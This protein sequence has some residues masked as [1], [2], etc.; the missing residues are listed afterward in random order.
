MEEEQELLRREEEIKEREARLEREE[1][2]RMAA[3]AAERAAQAE[4]E[5]EELLFQSALPPAEQTAGTNQQTSTSRAA[6]EPTSQTQK[7]LP[8][9]YTGPAE[10]KTEKSMDATPVG[11]KNAAPTFPP[12]Q[13]LPPSQT[14]Q[15]PPSQ[16]TWARPAPSFSAAGGG[17]AQPPAP[18]FSAAGGGLAEPPAPSFSAA[19]GGLAEPPAPSFSAAGGD[20]SFSVAGASAPTTAG[21]RPAE[22]TAA[23]SSSASGRAASAAAAHL[24]SQLGE[25]SSFVNP[26]PE[27]SQFSQPFPPHFRQD[28]SIGIAPEL[29]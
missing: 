25:K 12:S 5:Q 19:G 28:L 7:V 22:E 2:A 10:E 3:E 15:L 8:D 20:R 16:T 14:P 4:R 17:L 24:A 21:P 9:E 1:E 18:S 29:G 23:S 11:W 6:V 27:Q 13:Q 26:M